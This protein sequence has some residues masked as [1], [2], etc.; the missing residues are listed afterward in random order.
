MALGKFYEDDIHEWWVVEDLNTKQ[1][2]IE[3]RPKWKRL[4]GCESSSQDRPLAVGAAQ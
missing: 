1:R 4:L 2:I 3:V